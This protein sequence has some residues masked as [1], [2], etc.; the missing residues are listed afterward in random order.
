M[1]QILR[2]CLGQIARQ[3]SSEPRPAKCF[4]ARAGP[5]AARRR[6]WR[7]RKY[8]EPRIE[9]QKDWDA[10][11]GI[12]PL[13]TGTVRTPGISPTGPWRVRTSSK[14]FVSRW[15]PALKQVICSCESQDFQRAYP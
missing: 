5:L 9:T 15:I 10:Q 3:E 1:N 11:F 2:R 4:G 14:K 13:G 7:P 8:G 6:R 12:E